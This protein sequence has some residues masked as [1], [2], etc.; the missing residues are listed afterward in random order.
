[1]KPNEPKDSSPVLLKP[2]LVAQL[3]CCGRTTV[4]SLIRRGAIR[5]VVVGGLLRVPRSEIER[6][7]TCA[8]FKEG[9]LR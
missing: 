9:E 4:Y 8:T 1:M 7:A 3:L 5:S 2:A 6:L